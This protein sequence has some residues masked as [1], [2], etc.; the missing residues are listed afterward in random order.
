[1]YQL[2]K[3]YSTFK[4]QRNTPP[5]VTEEDELHSLGSIVLLFRT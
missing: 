3:H 1:M 4:R 5:P 2:D